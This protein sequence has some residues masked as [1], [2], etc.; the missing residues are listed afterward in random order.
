M[1]GFYEQFTL[2]GMMG[3]IYN[4]I[5][6]IGFLIKNMIW[7]RIVMIFGA[8]FEIIFF[9]LVGS[10]DL[11]IVIFY[12]TIW[13]L[14]NVIQ[15]Y[16]LIKDRLSLHFNENELLIYNLSF[17]SLSKVNFR[18]LLNISKLVNY[19][20]NTVVIEEGIESNQLIFI[21]KGVAVVDM[22]GQTTAFISAGN[23]IGEMSFISHELTSAKVTTLTP[24]ELLVWD[25]DGLAHLFTKHPEI[26][27]GLKTVFN[28]DLVKKLS[29]MKVKKLDLNQEFS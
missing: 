26:E 18:K 2:N 15:L 16:I 3:H 19:K 4:L 11:I 1:I 9:L 13:I 27:E 25:R 14:V 21:S 17:Y 23:F 8:L 12:C 20:E 5:Y 24:V 22:N 6:I 7:L 29:K 28:H 10:E